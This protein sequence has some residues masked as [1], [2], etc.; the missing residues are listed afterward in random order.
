M[1]TSMLNNGYGTAPI[2]DY[3]PKVLNIYKQIKTKYA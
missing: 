2:G 3:V 1:L